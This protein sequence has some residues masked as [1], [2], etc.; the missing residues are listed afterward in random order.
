M[1]NFFT[2]KRVTITGGQGFL[3]QV[4]KKKLDII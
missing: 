2:N 4:I 1:K 3:G